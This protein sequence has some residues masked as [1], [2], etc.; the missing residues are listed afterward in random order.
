MIASLRSFLDAVAAAAPDAGTVASL[1]EDLSGWTSRLAGFAAPEHAQI[2]AKHLDLP[3]R[4]QTM[5]PNFVVNGGDIS[6]VHGTVRFGRYFLGGGGAVHGGAVPLMFD[7]VLGRL[8]NSGGRPPSRTAYLN[9]DFR[10]I[11][12]ID[13]DLAVRGWFVSEQGRK[14]VLRAT[15]KHGDTVCAAAEGL[16]VSLLPN[17]P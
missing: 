5:A 9:T 3:G 13:A 11:T 8:A 4:G 6:S 10:S 1:A 2:F 15:I 16:F 12:P 7:E 14:R 17:Q